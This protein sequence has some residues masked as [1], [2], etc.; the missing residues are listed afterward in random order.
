MDIHINHFPLFNVD[1]LSH[2]TADQLQAL[3][4]LLNSQIIDK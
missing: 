4:E 2:Q 1:G 3:V